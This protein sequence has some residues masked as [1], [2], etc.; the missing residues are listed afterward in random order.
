MTTCGA[1]P[2]R[3]H[4]YRCKMESRR[5]VAQSLDVFVGRFWLEER[6]VN[7]A[8]PVVGGSGL[9]KN[10]AYSRSARVDNPVHPFRAS[11]ETFSGASAQVFLP[12]RI[13]V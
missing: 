9:A 8:G 4:A 2:G 3:I 11:I 7:Q 1:D 5:L 12:V 13:A 6:M 10:K